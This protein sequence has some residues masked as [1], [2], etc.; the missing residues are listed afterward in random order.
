MGRARFINNDSERHKTTLKFLMMHVYINP[1]T[2]IYGP[3]FWAIISNIHFIG[4]IIGYS[5]VYWCIISSTCEFPSIL[6]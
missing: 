4:E 6:P 5:P 2:G 1:W 3:V